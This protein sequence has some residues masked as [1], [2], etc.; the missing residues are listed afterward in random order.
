M[1]DSS[2]I[3]TSFPSQ[4]QEA[5]ALATSRHDIIEVDKKLF[6]QLLQ[7]VF[8][9]PDFG[10]QLAAINI[11]LASTATSEITVRLEPTDF[12]LRLNSALGTCR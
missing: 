2:I 1:S 7:L 12:L 9:L 5:K 4:Q 11:D 8:Q 10:S 3:E 6:K